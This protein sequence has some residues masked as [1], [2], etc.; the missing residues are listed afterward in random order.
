MPLF[1]LPKRT[2]KTQDKKAIKN[3]QKARV[4][5]PTIKACDSLL[6]RINQIKAKVETNLGQYRQEYQCI[7]NE[8]ILHDFITECIGNQYISI[9]TET[10]GLDPLQN[11]LAGICPYTYGQ[12]GS[13]IPLNHVSYITYAKDPN[14]LSEDFVRKEFKRLFEKK[15]EI[16]MFNAKFDI[17]FLRAF[18]LSDIYCTWDA[19][20]ASRILN[21]NEEH[22]NLK[23]LHNK[24]CLNGEGDAFRFDDLF[25]GILFTLIPYNY[26]FLYAA[27]DPVITTE[28]C[29]YQRKHL[30]DKTEREDIKNMY[31]VFKN[32]E[33]PCVDVVADMEDNGILFDNKYANELSV[34]YNALLKEKEEAFYKACEPY[35]D[36]IDLYRKGYTTSVVPKYEI[37]GGPGYIGPDFW[38]PN[39]DAGKMINHANINKLSD[40]INISSSTQIA[41]LLYDI[42]KVEPID[43]KKPRGTGEEILSKI[44][45]V[46]DEGVSTICKSILEYREMSKLISTYIDKLPDCV[47]P[48]DGRIHCSFNQYGADTGRMSSSEPNLQ[49]IPS[50]NHD[51]RKMF[52]AS[53]GHVLI[54]SDYSQQEPSCL[55]S[56]CK[57]L[58]Y[59]SLYDARANGEDIYSHIASACFEV[60]Y[61]MCCE[62]DKDGKKNPKEY[63]ERR[64]RAKPVLLGILYGRGDPSVAEGMGITIDEA[65][66]LKANLYK[67]Y[68]EIKAFEDE[69]IKM[70]ES[71]GY[72]TTICGRKRRLPSMLLPD[73]EFKYISGNTDVL[74]FADD[75]ELEVPEDIQDYWWNKITKARFTDKRKIFEQANKKGIWIIDHTKDKDYTKVV[76]AR[77]QGSAADLTKLAMIDLN[78][79]DELKALGFKLLIPVH[80]EVI[81]ECPIENAKECSELLKQVMSHAAE[82]IL[83]M[84]FDCDVELTDAWYGN[85][86]II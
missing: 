2:D 24:Y 65:K 14:Q 68:P 12:K 49:N 52:V 71:L 16:D 29:D 5:V 6:S 43:A 78:N 1:D 33:M 30:T 31:W 79:N 41:I 54:S 66:Q 81:A 39:K 7:T 77:I 10:D 22:K 47:N 36:S 17:R 58:G 63:K 34:K 73:Y 55:A 82:K 48:N 62:F 25:K 60:P 11:T 46:S 38:H 9:D 85:E 84:P 69:S 27:H 56:F 86:V 37:V 64:N 20:L 51:I 61:E 45:N 70:V 26:G 3:S 13:Y 67:Q 80:D 15:P 42:L 75:T 57:E 53:P 50:K 72:V 74:D 18:G 28:L 76:N 59:A 4:S 83:N 35:K 40:P 32:I 19:Y 44:A 21:E 23:Q 8:E